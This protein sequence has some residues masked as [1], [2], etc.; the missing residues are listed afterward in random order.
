[1][2]NAKLDESQAG[3]KTAGRYINN[4]RY[5]DDTTVRAFLMKIK[6]ESGKDS[7]KHNTQNMQIMT[8][9]SSTLWQIEGKKW[10]QWQIHWVSD[11]SHK[12]KRCLL[13]GWKVRQC[14]KKQ[15]DSFVNKGAYSQS[16]GFSSSYV[17]MWELDHKE[18]L[19]SKNWCF[20]AMVLEETLEESF[21]QQGDQTSQS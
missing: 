20:Q 19:V 3:I 15:R 17:R 2:W 9:G 13:L 18:G 4:L 7:L 21:W 14:I 12:I 5:A 1:M 11:S 16:Y 10:K 6:E 8:S